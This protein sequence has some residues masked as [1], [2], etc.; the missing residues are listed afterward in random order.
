MPLEVAGSKAHQGE[1]FP[2][3]SKSAGHHLACG[4]A[5]CMRRVVM[6]LCGMFACLACR[7]AVKWWRFHALDC[8]QYLC[9]AVSYAVANDV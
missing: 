7:R 5:G 3:Q 8:T 4:P 9:G 1:G 6:E 2:R